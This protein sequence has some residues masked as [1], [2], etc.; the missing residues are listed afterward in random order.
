MLV[1]RI[2]KQKSR[3]KEKLWA[4]RKSKENGI[5]I[6]IINRYTVKKRQNRVSSPLLH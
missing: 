2:K 1:A 5:I 4:E 3:E 6:P